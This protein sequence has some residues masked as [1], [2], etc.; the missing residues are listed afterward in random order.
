MTLS[1]A[2]KVVSELEE[3]IRRRLP[4]TAEIESHMEPADSAGE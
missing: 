1:A 3:R 4:S 2:H